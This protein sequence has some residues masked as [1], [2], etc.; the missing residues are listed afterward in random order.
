MRIKK[1]LPYLAIIASLAVVPLFVNA[2]PPRGGW[3]LGDVL[4]I[5]DEVAN[6]L[7]VIGFAV[8]LLVII[9]GGI[10]YM[11]AGGNEDKQKSAKKLI[12]QGL[13]GAAIIL[14]AGVI[15]DTIA[16]FLG[17]TPPA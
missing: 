13:I 14:L 12:I 16:S 17:V 3:S 10:G 2:Q 11:T 6:W 4:D 15:L 1:F 9:I 8:A 5:L 7:Y